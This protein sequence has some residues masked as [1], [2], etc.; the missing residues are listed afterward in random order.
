[1]RDRR[2]QSLYPAAGSVGI[3]HLKIGGVDTYIKIIWLA[4]RTI[5]KTGTRQ[6][7]VQTINF[8]YLDRNINR[9]I[10]DIIFDRW[11]RIEN[12]LR[13]FGNKI[14]S[15]HRR[16]RIACRHRID[17]C[18]AGGRRLCGIVDISACIARILCS[19]TDISI[20]TA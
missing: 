3:G 4:G 9:Y 16:Q 12:L 14:R 15:D 1:M 19:S 13:S 10:S 2:L 17:R 8:L 6:F 5:G 20:R 7:L 18:A 11:K